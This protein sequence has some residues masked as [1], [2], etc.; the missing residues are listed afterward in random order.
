MAEFDR[1]LHNE[2][3]EFFIPD[4]CAVQSILFLVIVSELLVVVFVLATA[5]G[6]SLNWEKLA[7]LSLLVEWIVL[8]CAAI[9][10]VSRP[11]LGRLVLYQS[12]ITSLLIIIT[13]TILISLLG[14]EFLPRYWPVEQTLWW[15]WR[16]V[17]VAL[18]LGGITL[19]YF[20]LQYQLRMRERFALQS[21]LQALQARIRPHFLFNTM[22][23]IASLIATQ[24]KKAEQVLEDLCELLRASL[25]EYRSK[26]TMAEELRLCRL[27]LLHIEQLR[28]DSR[29]QI[30]WQIDT[31]IESEQI[32]SLILQPLLENAVHHGVAQLRQ[33]GEILVRIFLQQQFICLQVGNPTSE[34][35]RDGNTSGYHLGLDNIAQRLAVLYGAAAEMDVEAKG[36]YHTVVLRC[37]RHQDSP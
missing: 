16:N 3:R 1:D 22:N 33:G 26:V 13:V 34:T 35:S 25:S 23:S 12:V 30:N 10:C 17:V 18:V 11:L 31:G 37:P 36:N 32:P 28:L 5:V 4:L 9:L 27:Y 19:R 14:R 24:P 7:L 2:N 21:K 20:Y 29:L 15:L 6:P 8:L